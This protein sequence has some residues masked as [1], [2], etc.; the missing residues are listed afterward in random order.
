MEEHA[1]QE[2]HH[3]PAVKMENTY[4]LGPGKKF[5]VG[6][7]KKI[8]SDVLQSYLMDERYE[9]EL[10]RNMTKTLSEVREN[11]IIIYEYVPIIN[12][13]FISLGCQS[14]SERTKIT[15]L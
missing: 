2:H 9:V 6:Q 15:P 4:Q 1:N 12:K 13:L 14:Q 3:K 11:K 7:I 10:C 8:I 5:P